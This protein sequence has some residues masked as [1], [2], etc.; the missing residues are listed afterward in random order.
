MSLRPF[1]LCFLFTIL[2]CMVI[3]KTEVA[4]AKD[5]IRLVE[6]IYQTKVIN[7][8]TLFQKAI[9]SRGKDYL[10]A[11]YLLRQGGSAA[12]NTLYQNRNHPDPI[13][14]LIVESLLLWLQGKASEHQAALDYLDYIPKRLAKTPVGSPPPLGVSNELRDRFGDRVANFLALRLVK[15]DDW[16]R[17]RVISILFYLS[18]QKLPSTTYAL[19]RFA[20]ET[21]NEEARNYAIEAIKAIGDK[22]LKAKLS[23]E[24]SR[25]QG[26]GL[27]KNWPSELDGLVNP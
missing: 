26:L 21:P 22:D 24:R 5:T 1:G 13:A 17:W 11:E 3:I 14:R 16:L 27:Q 19:I 20:V 9:E 12:V 25:L 6:K 2:I 7:M 8:D 23:F 4:M 10:D 15:Q 18:E